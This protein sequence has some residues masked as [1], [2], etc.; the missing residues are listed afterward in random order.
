MPSAAE[1]EA[2]H[3]SCLPVIT[4]ATG[5]PSERNDVSILWARVINIDRAPTFSSHRLRCCV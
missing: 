5:E 2:Q 1:G 4:G 3:I